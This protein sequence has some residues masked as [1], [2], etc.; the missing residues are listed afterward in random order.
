MLGILKRWHHRH[1]H[2][3]FDSGWHKLY[4]HVFSG[5]QRAVHATGWL[6]V[7]GTL[8]G[9]GAN[10]L[11]NWGLT[12]SQMWEQQAF[13]KLLEFHTLPAEQQLAMASLA[14]LPFVMHALW[15]TEEYWR[16]WIFHGHKTDAHLEE[17]PELKPATA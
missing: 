14:S 17:L 1:A 6:F 13:S 2:R 8:V 15:K 4:R 5:A 11:R 12:F 10:A 7:A 3:N 9:A 16:R